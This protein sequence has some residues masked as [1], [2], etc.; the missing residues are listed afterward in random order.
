MTTFPRPPN[1]QSRGLF[2][3]PFLWSWYMTVILVHGGGCCCREEV[4]YGLT[5]T[6][7]MRYGTLLN[8]IKGLMERYN[9]DLRA[10]VYVKNSVR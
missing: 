8:F 3:V 7:L 5:L 10:A 2:F 1:Q 9:Y 6:T 4:A